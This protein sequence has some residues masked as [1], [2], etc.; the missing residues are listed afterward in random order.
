MEKPGV[1]KP[2]SLD[3]LAPPDCEV[4][5]LLSSLGVVFDTTELIKLEFSAK[6]LK[7]YSVT[8][9][10]S[11]LYLLLV[12]CCVDLVS[13]ARVFLVQIRF[14]MQRKGGNWLS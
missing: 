6:A 11:A 5:Q 12:A 3:D 1:K 14:S 4:F 10:I 7:G 8:F 2:R 13:Y 9:T